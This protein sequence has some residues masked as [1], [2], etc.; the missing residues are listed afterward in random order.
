[1]V[2]SRTVP[3]TSVVLDEAEIE[4]VVSVLR[5]G[6][7]RE[8]AV[9][10]E[11]EERF[12]AE[13]GARYAVSAS[14]GTAALHLAYAALL[15]PGDEVL[16]PAFTFIATASMVVMAG[17]IPVFCD[18]DPRTFTLDVEDA[19]RRITR[20]TRAIAPVHLFGNPADV[21]AV[22][23]LASAHGL[24]I[25]WDA[26]HA[27]GARYRG[28]GL[29]EFGNVVCFSFYPSKNITTGEGGM[30]TTNDD[31]LAARLRLLRSH[32][33]AGKY[34]HTLLGFN[35]R[36]TD[37]MAALGLRQL[38]KLDNW[39]RCRRANAAALTEGLGGVKGITTPRE[40]PGGEHCFNVYSVLVDAE[41]AGCDRD[42]LGRRLATAGVETAVHYPRALHDQPALAPYAGDAPR[43]VSR[44]LCRRILALPVHPGLDA[45]DINRVV[46]TMRAAVSG[47]L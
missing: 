13:A 35:Y 32:G 2:R 15:E 14:S 28:H 34:R 38:D 3:I 31:E 9:C 12:A 39:I 18:V 6:R 29:G 5:S 19:R 7:L 45:G 24:R 36:L 30:A 16:V 42:E 46:E 26:A 8:G 25:V 4:A 23:D 47:Q 10:R 11:F 41:V 40:Q 27:L 20:R 44:E 22:H 1:M 43:P 37:V 21:S 17:A 33:A